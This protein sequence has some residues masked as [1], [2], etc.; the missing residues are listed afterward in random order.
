M[1]NDQDL[2]E[3]IIL[4]GSPAEKRELFGFEFQTPRRNIRKKFKLFARANY[5]RYFKVES[6]EFHDDYIDDFVASYYGENILRSGY[7]GCAKTSLKKLFDVF[8]LLNDNDE[9]RKYM[10]VL[11]RD[12]KNSRQIVTDAYNL[13]V[14]VRDIYGDQFERKGDTKREETMGGFTMANGR[15]YSAGTVGQT[16]RGHLQDANRPDWIWFEDVEDRESIRSMVVTQGVIEKCEEAI[17]GL[18]ID[19]NGSYFV[20]ANYISDQGTVQWFINKP[21]VKFVNTPLLLDDKDNSSSTWPAAFPPDKVEQIRKDA[22]DFFGEYQGDP[23]KSQNKFFDLERIRKDMKKC[24]EPD[25]ISA[26]VK[27]WEVYKPNHRY[28]L[29]SDHSEGVG[30]DSNT[31]ALFNFNTGDLAATQA[32]NQIGPDLHAY[33]CARVGS[34]FGNCIW[35]PESNNKCGGIVITTAKAIPYPNIFKY[36]TPGRTDEKKSEKYGWET[37]KKTKYTM[38]FEFRTDYNDGLIHIYDKDLL[39]E[40]KAYTNNDLNETKAGLITRHFD[41]LMAAAIGWQMK[42]Y[43]VKAAGKKSYA[44]AMQ[45]YIDSN[46]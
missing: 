17:N 12:G 43:A 25:R 24:R 15:K 23:Q 22:D 2:I 18:S 8:V 30:L 36:I 4:E 3:N 32:S 45:K 16:Q 6:P 39:A 19:T 35:A 10:K 26:G 21:S 29:G 7:R 34:E 38:L 41:L 9:Y 46:K 31:M 42:K 33:E 27:Y 13:V 44:N 28:G 14:E 37:N 11:T 40:M 20:T 5:T 1:Q